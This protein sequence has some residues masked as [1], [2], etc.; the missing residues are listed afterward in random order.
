MV[1]NSAAERELVSRLRNGD[2]DAVA[3]LKAMY[4]TRIHQ[5]AFRHLRNHE[6]AEEV[7]QDVL[8]KVFHKI[9]AFRGDAALSSWLYRITFNAAMSRLRRGKSRPQ[10]DVRDE[11]H[12]SPRAG[13]AEADWSALGDESALRSEL[14]SRFKRAIRRMPRIY[15]TPVLLR[16]VRGLTTEEAS[17]QLRV[18]V[19]TLKSRLHR[20]RLFLRTELGDFA[21][22]LTLHRAA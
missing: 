3:D 6:D 9:E 22:G 10:S 12:E 15:R 21:S 20:G 18:N 5:L 16:D 17:R 13:E 8:L 11:A 4:G 14:R 1:R 19:Q 7:T 2:P